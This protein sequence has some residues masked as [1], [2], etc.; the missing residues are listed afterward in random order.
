MKK[1]IIPILLL[2]FSVQSNAQDT[3]V[4][5]VTFEEAVE[6]N[7]KT[8]KPFLID[9]YTDWCGW[10][11]R[12]DKTTYQNETIVEYINKNFHAVKLDGEQ[13]EDITF[14]DY[15]FKFK[16]NGRRGYNEF[17]AVLLNGKLSYPTTVFMN[18]EMELL[19]RVPGYLDE[20]VMEQVTSYFA[21]EKYK[22]EKWEDFVKNFKSSL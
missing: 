8:P 3:K 21:D 7:K 20:R 4:N 11:K 5:W 18:K 13:K 10:C 2:L 12:M 6:L 16:P 14:K 17:A 15:T 1:L 22:T 9:I 19:D